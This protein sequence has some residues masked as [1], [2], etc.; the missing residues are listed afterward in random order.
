MDA[1]SISLIPIVMTL[2]SLC[3]YMDCAW[4][5]RKLVRTEHKGHAHKHEKSSAHHHRSKHH[6]KKSEIIRAT[7]MYRASKKNAA[8][9]SKE[10]YD[11][12]ADRYSQINADAYTE[13]EAYVSSNVQDEDVYKI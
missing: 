11:D 13:S 2:I 5:P 8:R 9:A 6:T 7:K 4:L 10:K 12:V 3:V 1:L